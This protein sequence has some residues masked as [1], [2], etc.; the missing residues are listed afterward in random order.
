MS[1]LCRSHHLF[2]LSFLILVL[3]LVYSYLPSFLISS[4]LLF[5]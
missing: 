5:L 1:L 2:I 4:Y 3:Y